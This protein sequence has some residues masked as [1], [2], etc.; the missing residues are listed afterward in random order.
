VADSSFF[1]FLERALA[2]IAAEV[3]AA[4]RRLDRALA[5]GSIRVTVDGDARCLR[6]HRGA[7]VLIADGD[8][9][10]ELRTTRGCVRD[11]VEA[12]RTLLD[13]VVSD[14][15]LLRGKPEDV[16][17][18]HDALIAFVEGAV[19]IRKGAALLEAYLGVSTTESVRCGPSDSTHATNEWSEP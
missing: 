12:R 14:E 11:L 18:M 17:R 4:F 5:G 15:L 19:R 1:V 7:S 8:Y 6:I 3:P 13:A 10:V 9:R 16:A 2:A